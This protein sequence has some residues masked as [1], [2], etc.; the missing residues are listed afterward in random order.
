MSKAQKY[1][2]VL[3]ILVI[4][5]AS[6]QVLVGAFIVA[7]PFI[8]EVEMTMELDGVLV[9]ARSFVVIAGSMLILLS[10]I[11]YVIAALGL[12]GA[13]DPN[14]IGPVLV[15][16]I[17][18]LL[19]ACL[20][21]INQAFVGSVDSSALVPNI[22]NIVVIGSVLLAALFIRKNQGSLVAEGPKDFSNPKKL[23]F[24]RFLEVYYALHIVFAVVSLVLLHKED[25]DLDFDMWLNLMAV[26]FEGIALWLI[27]RQKQYGRQII[28]GMSAVN[29]VVGSVH[30]AITGVFDPLTQVFLCSFDVVIILYFATSRRAKALMVQPFSVESAQAELEEEE[31]F[32]RLKTFAFWRNLAIYF[33]VFSV[34]GHWMEAAYC[35]LIKYGLIPGTYDPNSQIWSD[36]L[37]PFMVYGFGFVACVLLLFPLKNWLQENFKGNA[38]PLALSFIANALVCTAIEL[39]MGLMLNTPAGPDGKLPLWD[40]SDIPLNF[41][42]QVCMQNAL[43]FGMVATLMVWVV[44]PGLEKL[45][46]R[47]PRDV[48]NIVFVGV[49]VG[50][51][52]LYFLYY[53]NVQLPDFGPVSVDYDLSNS[54][55]DVG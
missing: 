6:L 30:N 10:I 13:K 16:S 32:F 1:L 28:I 38:A 4:V 54:S 19:F 37:Y 34:V 20:S 41:M 14:K 21:M 17:I 50:F 7:L 23:G 3:S 36:W 39:T 51:A 45:I 53:I 15:L 29:I 48:M 5:V 52:V 43:A 44:Y 9:D 49:L 47:L 8:A 55:T 35:T 40:Y 22:V 42:G 12:R 46:G 25:W 31:G 26:V 2:K 33:C 24:M 18:G 27:W 11:Q